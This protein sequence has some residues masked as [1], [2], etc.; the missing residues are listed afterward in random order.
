[1]TSEQIIQNIKMKTLGPVYV[2][3]GTEPFYIDNLIHIFEKEGLQ[4]DHNDFNVRVLYGHEVNWQTVVQEARNVPMFGEKILVI[5]RDAQNLSQF[6]E[7]SLYLDNPNPQ[8]TLVIEYKGKN[9][10][11]RTQF[12]KLINKKANHFISDT[13]KDYELPGWIQSHGQSLGLQIDGQMAQLLASYLG[14]DLKKI[15]N[16]FQKIKISIPNISALNREIV[17]EYI[18]ISKEFNVFEFADAL[19]LRQHDKMARIL[20][21][22][23]SNPKNFNMPITTG[24]I[25]N[26]LLKIYLC[27]Y[28]G[29]DTASDRKYGIFRTHRQAAQYIKLGT[30]HKLIKILKNIS[31][32]AV[33]IDNNSSQADILIKEMVV[34]FQLY[35]R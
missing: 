33:G 4:D 27:H 29:N 31:Q 21:F 18:G 26:Y 19:F 34:R 1:M 8:C 17:E 24:T 14:N 22:I 13:I 6:N 3:E 10:D 28:I 20:N 30:V 7:L 9:I 25:Y 35:I 23:S 15:D 32:Q 16:E 11:K 12:Y 5:L 2:L